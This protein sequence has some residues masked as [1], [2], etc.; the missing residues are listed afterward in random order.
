MRSKEQVLRSGV[1]QR[2]VRHFGTRLGKIRSWLRALP[3]PPFLQRGG[4]SSVECPHIAQILVN[5]V[6]RL[7][8]A[9]DGQT[10]LM[11]HLQ[12]PKQLQRRSSSASLVVSEV[13]RE[14]ARAPASRERLPICSMIA[15]PPSASQPSGLHPGGRC[16]RLSH[17]VLSRPLRVART[18]S[19]FARNYLHL[20]QTRHPSS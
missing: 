16:P 15:M 19:A 6:E 13:G 18:L 7:C 14:P 12:I 4:A 10:R 3:S 9:H 11:A 1:T 2:H 17:C 5:V 20:E 8:S